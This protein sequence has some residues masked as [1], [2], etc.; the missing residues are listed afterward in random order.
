MHC[1]QKNFNTLSDYFQ[2]LFFLLFAEPVSIS[3]YETV[4]GGRSLITFGPAFKTINPFFLRAVI[5]GATSN[6]EF[7]P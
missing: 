1:T 4:N 7:N 3:S 2:V 5:N 6:R